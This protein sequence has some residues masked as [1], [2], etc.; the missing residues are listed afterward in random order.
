MIISGVAASVPGQPR[1]TQDIGALAVAPEATWT[2]LAAA[3]ARHGIFPR[4]PAAVEFAA[5]MSMPDMLD[6]LERI[7][8]GRR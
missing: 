8:A 1:L 3:G 7:L 5:A 4:I 6:Q 2:T